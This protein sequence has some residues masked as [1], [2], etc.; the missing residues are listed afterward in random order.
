MTKKLSALEVS[1]PDSFENIQDAVN[2]AYLQN[3]SGSSLTGLLSTIMEAQNW[4][5]SDVQGGWKGYLEIGKNMGLILISENE[6]LSINPLILSLFLTG[7]S[8]KVSKRR[9][10]DLRS[11]LRE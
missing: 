2:S 1:T 9:D 5:V 8:T 11:E 10:E 4:T 3:G 6:T 7:L